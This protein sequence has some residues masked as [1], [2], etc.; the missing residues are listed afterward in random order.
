MT[1]EHFDGSPC[2]DSPSDSRS[3]VVVLLL[4]RTEA[5]TKREVL[6]PVCEEGRLVREKT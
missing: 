2:N 5:R 3:S 4:W 6:V 1:W